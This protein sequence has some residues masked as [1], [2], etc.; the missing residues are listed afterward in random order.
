MEDFLNNKEY[1]NSLTILFNPYV[2]ETALCQFKN[3]NGSL[4][5]IS[6]EIRYFIESATAEPY[7][8]RKFNN[9]LEK[10]KPISDQINLIA[11]RINTKSKNG[12]TNLIPSDKTAF[13]SCYT[14][15]KEFNSVRE[16][17][18]KRHPVSEYRLWKATQNK[19]GTKKK[20][21]SIR[22]SYF[23]KKKIKELSS[24]TGL[25]YS[26]IITCFMLGTPLHL[27]P[28]NEGNDNLELIDKTRTNL[29]Q[30][31]IKIEAGSISFNNEESKR[32]YIKAIE[33]LLSVLKQIKEKE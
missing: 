16:L 14:L 4:N 3:N 27:R 5:N 22:I 32:K 29:N 19:I 7:L 17:K 33:L 11:K 2:F 9:Y 15:S 24:K 10:L 26:D 1:Q 18:S 21:L 6:D 30:I 13:Q 8:D 23:L 31:L 20:K 12:K 28:F 25:N